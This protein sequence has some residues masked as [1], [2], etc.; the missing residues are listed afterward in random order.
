M[1]SYNFIVSET[2]ADLRL[3]VYA[4]TVCLPDESRSKIKKYIKSGVIKVN[5]HKVPPSY[6]VKEHDS[7]DFSPALY[8]QD[9]TLH[10]EKIPLDII[11]DDADIL[12]VNKQPGL[13]VH[14]AAGN[15]THTMVNALKYYF[16]ENLSEYGGADR[17]GIV[18]RLDKETSGLM[19]VAKNDAAH[20]NLAQQFKDR[21][22]KKEY[23]VL[24][25]GVV[26]HDQGK[27]DQ[28]IGKA[29]VFRKKMVVEHGTGK[30][31]FSEYSV[32]K[33]FPNATLLQV[34]IHT[35]RTHQIRVHMAYLGHPVMG[36]LVYGVSSSLIP[37]QCLHASKLELRH[38]KTHR[39][40]VFEA[41][42]PDDIRSAID[43]LSVANQ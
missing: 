40:M 34:K 36:D 18:H 19:I 22:V 20:K 32:L 11:Y 37:R 3:D 7:I 1:D 42:L 10:P 8:V 5:A 31:A 29:K 23:T 35:G 4:A 26:Q 14:P 30:N 16:G 9:D 39:L 24:V 12:I 21:I 27:C 41:P 17:A 2:H 43:A 28:P 33:R 38:P 13:V 15:K 6:S 25:K